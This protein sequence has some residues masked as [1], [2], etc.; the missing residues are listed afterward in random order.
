MI[1]VGF[2]F[3]WKAT[4]GKLR[5]M[6]KHL[7]G[8]S[9][10]SW[11]GKLPRNWSLF[12]QRHSLQVGLL[13]D[14]DN[15]LSILHIFLRACALTCATESNNAENKTNNYVIFRTMNMLSLWRLGPDL[16]LY[17]ASWDYCDGW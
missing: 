3:K 7:T 8:T 5:N 11:V 2:N 10:I 13:R 17:W 12:C 4:G 16:G 15:L 6:Y 1:K 14:L 9:T